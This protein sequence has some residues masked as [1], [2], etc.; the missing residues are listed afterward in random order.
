MEAAMRR[1]KRTRSIG[2]LLGAA[3]LLA[4]CAT[5]GPYAYAPGYDCAGCYGYGFYGGKFDGR[6]HHHYY[7]HD[8]PDH[9]F[10]HGGFGHG[11]GHGGGGH[12]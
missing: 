7:Y 11:G 1:G 8:T 9:G 3:L 10:G 5:G 6:F 12:R 2:L 4:S